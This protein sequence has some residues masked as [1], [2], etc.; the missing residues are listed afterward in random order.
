[1]HADRPFVPSDSAQVA[2]KPSHSAAPT[3]A[4]PTPEVTSSSLAQ[5]AS[6]LVDATSDRSALDQETAEKLRSSDFMA[7]MRDFAEGR[8]DVHGEEVVDARIR[9]GWASSREGDE[10]WAQDFSRGGKSKARDLSGALEDLSLSGRASPG[11]SVHFLPDIASPYT[12]MSDAELRAATAI[13]AA[14]SMRWEEDMN[15]D[16]AQEAF[17]FYNGP[18]QAQQ[19][20]HTAINDREGQVDGL[21]LDVGQTPSYVF[22][23]ANPWQDERFAQAQRAAALD[24]DS[25]VRFL[26]CCWHDPQLTDAPAPKQSVLQQEAKVLQ[27]PG[28][29]HAWLELGIKQQENEVRL[30]LPE[31]D[32][33]SGR[34]C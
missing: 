12:T 32:G 7:L 9:E 13:P 8:K 1:M 20:N 15:D 31:G 26:A 29:A 27:N 28:D 18:P 3:Y 10:G 16:Q 14:S 21:S 11:R 23:K 2:Q 33:H 30:R 22:Q 19:R 24:A 34:L 25:Q 4:A 6:L 5:T 17:L